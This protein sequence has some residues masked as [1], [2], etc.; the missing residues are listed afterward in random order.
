M[1]LVNMSMRNRVVPAQKR[2]G[3]NNL[4]TGLILII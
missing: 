3:S 1:V 4:T 2:H